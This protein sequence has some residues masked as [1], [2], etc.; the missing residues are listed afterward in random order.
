M[1]TLPHSNT[2][3]ADAELLLAQ[4]GQSLKSDTLDAVVAQP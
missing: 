1:N 4:E 3:L 2:L